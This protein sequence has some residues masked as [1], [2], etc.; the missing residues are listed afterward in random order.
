MTPKQAAY[1]LFEIGWT[2]KHIAAALKISETTISKWAKK[3]DWDGERAKN[4]AADE[5]NEARLKKLI[6]Y[7]L[8]VLQLKTEEWEQ[9]GELK[10]IER[11]DVDALSKLYSSI[12]GKEHTWAQQVELITEFIGF[13]E[14]KSLDL[15]KK[16]LPLG[17]EFVTGKKASVNG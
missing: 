12:K 6:N 5:A 2:Q 15:A 14:K 1:D 13:V 16:L 10:L 7:N 17:D 4:T 8:R 11:G 3:Y 9:A